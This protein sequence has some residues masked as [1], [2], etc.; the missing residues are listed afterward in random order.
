MENQTIITLVSFIFTAGVIYGALN[1]RIKALEK[2]QMDN[3]DTPVRLARIEEK[4][5]LVIN[6][7]LKNG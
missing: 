1:T 6:H 2:N 4:L 7:F 3:Q 5:T